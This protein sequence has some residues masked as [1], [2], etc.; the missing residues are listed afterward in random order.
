MRRVA[1]GF[2][3]R[4]ARRFPVSSAVGS[5]TLVVRIGGWLF[6][7]RTS[8]PIPLAIP[9]LFVRSGEAEAGTGLLVCGI[10]L[11]VIGELIRV[12]GVHHIGAVS[13]TRSDRYGPL[14][15][16]G[17]FAVVRNPLYLGN[18]SIWLGFAFVARLPWMAP[19]VLVVLALEYH[20]IVRW[21]EQ[22]LE[23]RLGD[24]YRA[25]LAQVPRW[26][27]TFT[28]TDLA[29]AARSYSWRETFFSERGTLIAIAV[30]SL[31]VWLK[32]KS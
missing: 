30:G 16:S 18:I 9:L 28:P 21:E 12:W 6:R 25:Y 13:R 19:V 10:I 1:P 17:P 32:L 24:H 23:S 4:S 15:A 8:L 27:P 20:A 22:F 31:A 2:R 11:V 26:L 3:V 7:H 5:S 29:P 14:V